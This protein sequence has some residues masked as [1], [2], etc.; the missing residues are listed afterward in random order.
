[1]FVYA[2][3]SLHLLGNPAWQQIATTGVPNRNMLIPSFLQHDSEPLAHPLPRLAPP[4]PSR[5][6]RA[7]IRR[8][9]GANLPAPAPPVVRATAPPPPRLPRSVAPRRASQ[10]HQGLQLQQGGVPPR[11]TAFALLLRS[12]ENLPHRY[13]DPP[14]HLVTGSCIV[15]FPNKVPLGPPL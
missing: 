9:K 12:R 14:Y 13:Q 4:P 15:H 7:G 10:D 6:V 11:S 2:A 5:E 3:R 8:G 1:M